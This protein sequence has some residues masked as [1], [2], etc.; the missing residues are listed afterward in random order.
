[1]AAKACIRDAGRVL[2]MSYGHTD[3]IAKLIPATLGIELKTALTESADLRAMLER[4]EDARNLMRL[5]LKLEGLTRNAGKHAGGVVI[6]PT[7]DLR[8]A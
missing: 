7:P 6:A 5:A 2:G 4:D 1:M 3:S 8:A